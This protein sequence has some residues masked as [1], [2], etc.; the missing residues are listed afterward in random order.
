MDYIPALFLAIKRRDTPV[1]AKILAGIIVGYA[2]SPI[3][4]IPDFVPV[5]GYLDD[6][7]LLPLLIV[8]TIG[9]I[10]AE[11]MAECKE[12]A[13]KIWQDGKPEKWHYAIPVIIIYLLIIWWILSKFI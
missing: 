4:I 9:L 8:L 11:I 2:L 13:E 7:I 5:L 6:I 10:P 12:E 1:I 3:D